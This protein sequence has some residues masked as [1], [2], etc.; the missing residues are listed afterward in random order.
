[1]AWDAFSQDDA[2]LSQERNRA[3]DLRQT[4]WWKRELARGVCHYCGRKTPPAELTMDH[5]VP[6][7]RGGKSVKG[8]VVPCCKECNNN[9]KSLLPMEWDQYLEQVRRD[10]S[11]KGE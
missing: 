8:N 9:K 3:R 1:M 6:I 2:L 7:S 5:V 10:D 11:D 4:Q